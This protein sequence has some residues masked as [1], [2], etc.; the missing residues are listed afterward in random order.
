MHG[1][2]QIQQA[3]RR[4][5]REA[6]RIERRVEHALAARASCRDRDRRCAAC[7]LAWPRRLRTGRPCHRD[8]G[9]P[10]RSACRA[11]PDVKGPI[12]ARRRQH[13][14]CARHVGGHR[15]GGR[16]FRSSAFHVG[17]LGRPI[18]FSREHIDARSFHPHFDRVIPAV[19]RI[20]GRGIAEE[21]ERARILDD[22][23][24]RPRR[25]VGAHECLAA[26]IGRDRPELTG[27]VAVEPAWIERVDGN[28]V[29]VRRSG[30]FLHQR[31]LVVAEPGQPLGDEDDR[32][33][34][35][36]QASQVHGGRLHSRERHLGAH[37]CD[38]P[39]PCLRVLGGAAGRHVDAE[40]ALELLNPGRE[41]RVIA[42]ETQRAHRQKGIHQRDQIRRPERRGDEVRQR[43][44]ALDCVDEASDVVLIP[45]N[46][47]HPHVVARRLGGGVLGRANGERDVLA[48]GRAAV[49]RHELEGLNRLWNSVFFDR[50]VFRRQRAHRLAVV[51]DDGDVHADEARFGP[52]RGRL[53]RLCGRRR[54]C[55]REPDQQGR[56][57]GS[58]PAHDSR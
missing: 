14:P 35:F 16:G 28:V 34:P 27:V 7:S 41:L 52:K 10:V 55:I 54:C 1:Y 45:E 3:R 40:T 21:V 18:P 31:R 42:G 23:P 58:A 39:P 57:A 47:K 12:R 17:Q 50:E 46:Q 51:V 37:A 36:L 8:L 11:C 20:A 15:V 44:A 29:G 56:D 43:L 32:L 19:G 13:G 24:Q 38:V 53:R 5:K 6:A 25:R 22:L 49:G 4:R 48:G 33:P 2:L 26:G 9:L 30:H